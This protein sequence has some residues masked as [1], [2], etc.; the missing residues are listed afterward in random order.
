LPIENSCI[1][2]NSS[3]INKRSHAK[4]C[5]SRCRTALSRLSRTKPV[6]LKLV[7]S[8]I[9]FES[10]KLQAD[11]LGVLVNQLAIERITKPFINVGVT[12]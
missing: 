3:L 5:S 8:K 7:F 2:C 1:I 12:V 11:S 6:S 10:L 9:Q 4:T